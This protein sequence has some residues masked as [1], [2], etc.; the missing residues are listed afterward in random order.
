MILSTSAAGGQC[1]HF[2]QFFTHSHLGQ[3]SHQARPLAPAHACVDACCRFRSS[4]EAR[5]LADVMHMDIPFEVADAGCCG[6]GALAHGH[7]YAP[8]AGN[9]NGAYAHIVRWI[10]TLATTWVMAFHKSCMSIAVQDLCVHIL[11]KWHSASYGHQRN[12]LWALGLRTN[13]HYKELRR[14]GHHK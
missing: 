4:D 8:P 10:K 2:P 5:R 3:Q 6:V 12:C 11:C 14:F 13:W 1:M 9:V 7:E